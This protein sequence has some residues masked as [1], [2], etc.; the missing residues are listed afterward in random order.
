MCHLIDSLLTF[1]TDEK[2]IESISLP[3]SSRAEKATYKP[4]IEVL[5]DDSD[6]DSDENDD[7]LWARPTE[8]KPKLVEDISNETDIEK[9]RKLVE[10]IGGDFTQGPE[11]QK[12]TEVLPGA[13]QL[14]N[15]PNSM[16]IVMEYTEEEKKYAAMSKEEKIQDLAENLGSGRGRK[17][18][19][20]D[21]WQPDD[22][23]D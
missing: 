3:A 23:L 10:D 13:G 21:I 4:K 5:D 6:T 14:I 16:R 22:E 17:F 15:N 12:P 1:S 7:N 18:D 19:N 9:T 20:M 2:S 11:K 8:D